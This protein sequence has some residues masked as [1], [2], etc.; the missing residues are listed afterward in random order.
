MIHLTVLR[1][2]ASQQHRTGWATYRILGWIGAR[3]LANTAQRKTTA[4]TTGSTQW[5]HKSMGGVKRLLLSLEMAGHGVIFG[6]GNIGHDLD[7]YFGFSRMI[8]TA[9]VFCSRT[10]DCLSKKADRETKESV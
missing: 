5:D 6:K 7:W 8:R 10:K 1:I 2:F 9:S 3:L 4:D